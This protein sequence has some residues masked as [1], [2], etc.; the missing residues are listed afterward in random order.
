MF[1]F[2]YYKSPK[3]IINF[4]L[5]ALLV[6]AWVT[7][8]FYTVIN[9]LDYI[10]QVFIGQLVGFFYLVAMLVFD[11]EIHKY[12]L[13]A[14]FSMRSSRARK[15][16]LFFFLIALFVIVVIFYYS[17]T[18]TWTMPQN[19]I[20]NAN[21]Y[22]SKECDA[23][24]Q[25]EADN[26][27]GLAQTYTKSAVLF[28]LIGMIFAWPYAMHHFSALQWLNTPLWKR[29]IRMVLGVAS[30]YG[31]NF[32]FQWCVKGVN[33]LATKYFFGCALPGFLSAYWVF[34]FF[35]IICKWMGLVQKEEEYAKQFPDVI[36]QVGANDKLNRSQ[37]KSTASNN[38][39]LI[40]KSANQSP[41]PMKRGGN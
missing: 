11:N 33:D 34:G 7:V 39:S 19:W 17:F 32:F 29:L 3:V 40:S 5:L 35:P 30:A 13:R 4:I 22:R 26:Q 28:V 15:F 37:L 12:T 8:Y 6:C 10:Y 24:F 16:Y 41:S 14:G 1:G 36:A 38:V 27:I 23:K 18:A 25:E 21:M 20:V 31:I 2:K 9:G